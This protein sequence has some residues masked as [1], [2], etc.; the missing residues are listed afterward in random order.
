[1]LKLA[2]LMNVV[3]MAVLMT[4]MAAGP[5]AARNHGGDR[6]AIHGSPSEHG[7]RITVADDGDG[8]PPDIEQRLFTP[9]VHRGDRPLITGSVGLGL[10]I[11]RLL[12]EAMGGAI[13]YERDE[14]ETRFLVDLP[15]PPQDPAPAP[16]DEVIEDEAVD[17]PAEEPVPKA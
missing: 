8:V 16:V 9:F 11:T 5:G 6:V 14:G 17:E 12:T 13:T 10:S 15:I 7:Y 2:K 3:L 1:M 4:M